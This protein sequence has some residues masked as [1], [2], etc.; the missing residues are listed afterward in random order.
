MRKDERQNTFEM[1]ECPLKSD[2]SVIRAFKTV[3]FISINI[4]KMMALH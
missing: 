3:T 1:I 4:M 2:C